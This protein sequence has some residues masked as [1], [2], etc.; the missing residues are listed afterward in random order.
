MELNGLKKRGV[1]PLIDKK[2][3]LM[4]EGIKGLRELI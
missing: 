3:K 1:A 2:C 4:E